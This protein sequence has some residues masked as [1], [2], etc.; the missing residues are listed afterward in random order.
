MEAGDAI[1]GLDG[2]AAFG[3]LSIAVPFHPVMS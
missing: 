2:S 3:A 1:V